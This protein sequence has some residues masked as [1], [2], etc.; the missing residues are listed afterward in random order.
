MRIAITY[1]KE[2]GNI[3]PHFGSCQ[4]FKFYEIKD[5]K[6]ALSYVLD[7]RGS[8]HEEIADFLVENKVDAV[9]CGGIGGGAY[10]ALY[11][12]GIL[13]YGGIVGNADAA[14]DLLLNDKLTYVRES[15]CPH[16]DSEGCHCH[17][18]DGCACE[19]EDCSCCDGCE[20][21]VFANEL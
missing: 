6:V 20:D 3:F 17:G 5:K 7:T 15:N 4:A 14:I 16:H 10:S 18:E 13:L 21:E 12:A 11:D 2:T 8:G 9:L 19:G 1:D